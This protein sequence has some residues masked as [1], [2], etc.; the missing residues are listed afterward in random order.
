MISLREIELR[1]AEVI[2]CWRNDKETVDLLGANFRYINLQTDKDWIVNY[3]NNRGTQVR[4]A[5]CENN[6]VIGLISLVNIDSINRKAEMHLM[7]GDVDSRGKGYGKKAVDL[8]LNHGF[9]NMN[10]NKIYLSTLSTNNI[11]KRMYLSVGFKEEGIMRE[12]S[13]KNGKYQDSI[14]MS[15]LAKEYREK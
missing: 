10:L 12:D 9:N 11:A 14:M 15:I 7:I 4:C 1:D 5:I 6:K 2:N 3:Q 13:Y 8:M